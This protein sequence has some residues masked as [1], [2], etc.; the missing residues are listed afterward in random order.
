MTKKASKQKALGLSKIP[1]SNNPWIDGLNDGYSWSSGLKNKPKIFYRFKRRPGTKSTQ[2]WS[3]AERKRITEAFDSI[4]QVTPLT[5]KKL[6]GKGNN[7]TAHLLLYLETHLTIQRAFGNAISPRHSPQDGVIK[8]NSEYYKNDQGKFFKPFN[9]G[10]F[11]GITFLH[12]I[13]H[14]LGLK[15][16]HDRGLNGE[17]RFPGLTRNSNRFTDK[18]KFGMNA[19]PYTQMTY[20]FD[21]AEDMERTIDNA[22]SISNGFLLGPGA[23]DI[24]ALQWIYGTNTKTNKDNSTYVLPAKNK[25]GTG[26]SC[27]WDT[28]G[29]DL[30]SAR[31]ART[32][33]TI[34]LRPATLAKDQYAGGYL[35]QVEGIRGGFTI[36]KKLDSAKQTIENLIENA[37]GGSFNDHITGNTAANT[38]QGGAGDDTINGMQGMDQLEGGAGNDTLITQLDGD[39]IVG[40]SGK[41]IYVIEMRKKKQP[42]AKTT[43]NDFS[44]TDGDELHIII[45]HKETIK[46]SDPKALLESDN[47]LPFDLTL[48]SQHDGSTQTYTLTFSP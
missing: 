45:N 42:L 47:K 23:L 46:S 43:I 22:T 38:L 29:I 40:G 11:L 36:A 28:G 4:S 39:S 5:F 25:K 8:I 9:A 44:R 12:E 34:D 13:C 2:A 14:G 20:A 21:M 3:R 15:H 33:S 30:I 26:W 41:D 35:S 18:G 19:F 27:I 16:P 17:R 1:I 24:A 37:E 31:R 48:E 7:K 10:S 32:N 6:E